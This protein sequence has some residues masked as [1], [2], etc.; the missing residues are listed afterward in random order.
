MQKFKRVKNYCSINGIRVSVADYERK[1]RL[2]YERKAKIKPEKRIKRE[3]IHGHFK[4]RD[5]LT[6]QFI[7]KVIPYKVRAEKRLI[8]PKIEIVKKVHIK[9]YPVKIDISKIGNLEKQSEKIK[10]I[11][12]RLAKKQ[13]EFIASGYTLKLETYIKPQERVIKRVKVKGKFK[14]FNQKTGKE[15]TKKQYERFKRMRAKKRIVKEREIEFEKG[16]R[17]RIIKTKTELHEALQESK[18]YLIEYV[19]KRR[20]QKLLD[21]GYQFIDRADLT[22]NFYFI[23]KKQDVIIH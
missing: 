7:K 10:R 13:K 18:I 19:T 11:Y 12:D 4:Y 16:E 3:I 23:P 9:K 6:G 20:R 1:H 2:Y 21:D 5:M 14:Y 22:L 17:D 8:E 15:T